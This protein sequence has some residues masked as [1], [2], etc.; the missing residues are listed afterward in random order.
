MER[1]RNLSG[2][3]GSIAVSKTVG[4]GSNPCWGANLEGIM[5]QRVKILFFALTI[6]FIVAYFIYGGFI[7]FSPRL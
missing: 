3:T 2:V 1:E 6:L 4:R 5:G 7:M